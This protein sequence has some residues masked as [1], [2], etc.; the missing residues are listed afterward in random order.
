MP[1][2]TVENPPTTQIKNI[3]HLKA[4]PTDNNSYLLYPLPVP[5][6]V[7][8]GMLPLIPV[9]GSNMLNCERLMYASL[10]KEAY[11]FPEKQCLY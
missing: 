5:S 10:K 8:F 3:W 1:L 9:S 7:F 2:Y 6:P 4:F 11:Y